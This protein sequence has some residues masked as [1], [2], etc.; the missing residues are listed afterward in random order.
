MGECASAESHTSRTSISSPS[1]EWG[2]FRTAKS[3]PPL[4]VAVEAPGA[5]DAKAAPVKSPSVVP[6]PA[7][8][9]NHK[10]EE[11]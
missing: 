6:A 1:P 3:A 8:R 11:L 7:N 2:G 9:I 5:L 4:H 10:H